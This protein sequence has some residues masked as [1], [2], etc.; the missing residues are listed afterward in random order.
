MRINTW[1]FFHTDYQQKQFGFGVS[2]RMEMIHY[3]CG[4]SDDYNPGK[5]DQ[6]RDQV[7][8]GIEPLR[9]AKLRRQLPGGRVE[10][11]LQAQRHNQQNNATLETQRM[12]NANYNQTYYDCLTGS[13]DEME[14]RT[15]TLWS[16]TPKKD[17]PV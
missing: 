3:L 7:G 5:K 1:G 17:I 2:S 13:S 6:G 9:S 4:G 12:W 8:E 14:S 15:L 10:S 16:A 11:H